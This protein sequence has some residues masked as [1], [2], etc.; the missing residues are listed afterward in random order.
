MRDPSFGWELPPGCRENDPNAPWNDNT[1]D[2]CPMCQGENRDE[3]GNLLHDDG[4]CS[5]ECARKFEQMRDD[6][7]ISHWEDLHE[8]RYF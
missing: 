8:R 3:Q 5:T 7:A 6:A 4:F 2:E 1:P